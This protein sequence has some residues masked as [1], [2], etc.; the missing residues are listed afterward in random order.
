M[1][2]HIRWKVFFAVIAGCAAC[3]A[4][5]L[6][7]R[8]WLWGAAGFAP[9]VGLGIY[10]VLQTRHA[11]LR[12]FPLLGHL[13]YLLEDLGPELNQYFVEGDLNGR[14]FNR[15]QRSLVYQRA[16]SV[17]DE[18][19]FGTQL[20]VYSAEYQWIN[21]SIAPRDKQADA[22]RAPSRSS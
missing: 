10:D 5:A 15:D 9:L 18:T 20:D 7:D 4:L 8:S 6:Q 14:P 11:V 19:P 17:I 13:R 21:H 16:K 12:N 3:L 1:I 2:D 22:P